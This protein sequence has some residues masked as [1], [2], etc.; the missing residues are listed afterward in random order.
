MKPFME[1]YYCPHREFC[2]KNGWKC[3]RPEKEGDEE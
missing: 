3:K 2:E 1:C